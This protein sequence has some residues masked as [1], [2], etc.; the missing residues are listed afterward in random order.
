MKEK[1]TKEYARPGNL[2]NP[3]YMISKVKERTERKNGERK[4]MKEMRIASTSFGKVRSWS[5]RLNKGR[6][7]K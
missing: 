3:L 7:T 5:R 4:N 2:F 6:G 1:G